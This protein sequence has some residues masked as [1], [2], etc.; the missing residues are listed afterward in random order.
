MRPSE[1]AAE[2]LQEICLCVCK[3]E[4]TYKLTANEKD[5]VYETVPAIRPSRKVSLELYGRIR[6]TKIYK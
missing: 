6:G 1:N 3:K 5:F 2:S 4:L